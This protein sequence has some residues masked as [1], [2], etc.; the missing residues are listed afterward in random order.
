MFKPAKMQKIRLVALNSIAKELVAELH[1]HGVIE[2]SKFN[3]S[4][5]DTNIPFE[6]YANI[7]SKIVK[8]RFILSVLQ[9]YSV[10]DSRKKISEDKIDAFEQ[11]V[12]SLSAEYSEIKNNLKKYKENISFSEILNYFNVNFSFLST[13]YTDY[14][15]GMIS[16]KNFA[17]C[18][19]KLENYKEDVRYIYKITKKEVFFLFI[20][21]NE[22]SIDILLNEFSFAKLNVPEEV[23]D[24]K[25]YKNLIISKIQKQNINLSAIDSRLNFLAENYYS[26]LNKILQKYEIQSERSEIAS[27]FGFSEKIF[28]IEGWI[29]KSKMNLISKKLFEKFKEKAHLIEVSNPKDKPPTKLENPSSMNT[30]EYFVKMFSLPNSKELDPTFLFFFTA[31]LFYGMIMGDVIYGILSLFVSWFLLWKLKPTGLL[32]FTIRL[33][34]FASIPAIF[35]GVIYDEWMALSHVQF[36]EFLGEIG[37]H[38]NLTQPL[39]TGFS[40]IHN[41]TQLVGI[42]ALIGVL[43]LALGFVIGAY[44]EWGHNKK[45]AIAKLGWLGIDI[46]GTLAI[47]TLMF[48]MFPAELGTFS[49]AVLGICILI[50]I[51]VEGIIGVLEIPGLAGNILSYTRI[52]AVGVVGIVLAEIINEFILPFINSSDILMVA[53][54]L[55]VLILMHAVNTLIVMVE[56]LIQG[57]R[58]NIVEF[59]SKFLHGGGRIFSPF[60]LK[61]EEEK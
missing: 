40:R 44:N 9:K 5:M 33:W 42:S 61:K 39:Y 4:E 8:I 31:P 59:Q 6:D 16:R 29:E 14:T 21:R 22:I 19:S 46:F 43:N 53:V 24:P 23:S 32:L 18:I 52:A 11:E 56:A 1:S 60:A 41:L 51:W 20:H 57:G 54:M 13:E 28:L 10:K 38:I 17:K 3:E 35:F 37:I 25:E 7:S 34:I 12:R 49:L 36:A 48:S 30:I 47:M 2:I 58:L 50:V 26:P 27:K 55:P 45:H 15:L